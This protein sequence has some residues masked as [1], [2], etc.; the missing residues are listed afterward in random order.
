MKKRLLELILVVT[1][2]YLS[3]FLLWFLWNHFAL[4]IHH[5]DFKITYEAAATLI[6]LLHVVIGYSGF[7]RK[8]L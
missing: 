3:S 6:F 8:H 5:G 1:F 4:S 7:I 2:F